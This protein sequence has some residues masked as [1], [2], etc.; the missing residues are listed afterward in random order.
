MTSHYR[1]MTDKE[2]LNEIKKGDTLYLDAEFNDKALHTCTA[3]ED[4]YEILDPDSNELVTNVKGSDGEIH[5][6]HDICKLKGEQ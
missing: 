4:P 1:L 3:I 6:T 2:I 5:S